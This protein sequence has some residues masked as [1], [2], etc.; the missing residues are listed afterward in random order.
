M[1]C[2]L[3]DTEIPAGILTVEDNENEIEVGYSCPG[4]LRSYYCLV[5]AR[6]FIPVD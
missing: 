1:N 4:C 3:C 2:P 6:S 5:V